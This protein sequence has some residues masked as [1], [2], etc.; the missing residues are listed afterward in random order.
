MTILYRVPHLPSKSDL[1]RQAGEIRLRGQV[2]KNYGSTGL[3]RQPTDSM[4]SQQV[5]RVEK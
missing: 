3:I 5:C 2:S 4:G 1:V